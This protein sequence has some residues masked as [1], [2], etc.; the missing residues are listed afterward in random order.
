MHS[1]F[2][3][4]FCDLYPEYASEAGV[5]EPVGIRELHTLPDQAQTPQDTKDIAS[6]LYTISTRIDSSSPTV[7]ILAAGKGSRMGEG[8]K[9]K[10]LAPVLGRPAL[11]RTIDTY[12][13]FGFRNFI[14]IIGVGY[15]EV[16]T[17]LQQ[18]NIQAIFLYQDKQLG[19]GH[20]AQLA[21]RFLRQQANTNGIIMTMGDKVVTPRALQQILDNHAK[22]NSDLTITSASKNAWPDGGRV[23]LDDNGQVLS[24]IEKPDIIYKV[25][26]NDIQTWPTN[27]ITSHAL[28]QKLESRWSRQEKLKRM[29]GPRFWDYLMNNTS[30]DKEIALSLLPDSCPTIHIGNAELPAEEVEHHCT[31]VNVA[32]YYFSLRAF[33]DALDHLET[34][35]AQ[36]EYYITDAVSY[37][38]SVSHVKNYRVL[39]SKTPSDYDVMGFNTLE[40]LHRVET[41]LRKENAFAFPE[42]SIP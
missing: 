25:I 37:L 39:S 10:V 33:Y 40:E 12:K 41:I 8:I 18:E 23:Y 35:N 5:Y 14:L 28:Q 21:A 17:A 19:T 32:L 16:I 26:V 42:E 6:Y 11:L 9:Q 38:V 22:T 3:S 31:Q 13:K 7:I 24:I 36:G 4:T 30:L 15:K 2:L 34:N 20:A 29:V 27:P 1:N